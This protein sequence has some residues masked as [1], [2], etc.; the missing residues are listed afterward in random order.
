MFCMWLLRTQL[1]VVAMAVF[2]PRS[3]Y[4]WLVEMRSIEIKYISKWTYGQ[5]GYQWVSSEPIDWRAIDEKSIG[6]M[7]S[8]FASGF[9]LNFEL[10]MEF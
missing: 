2:Y 4:G 5:N 3:E 10:L 9:D 7:K 8:Y 1:P 6:N